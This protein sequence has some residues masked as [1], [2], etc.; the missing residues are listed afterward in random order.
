MGMRLVVLHQ[1]IRPSPSLPTLPNDS[2][3]EV[4]GDR[5]TAR[6]R[7]IHCRLW[8]VKSGGD[9]QGESEAH[10][11]IAP[12]AD[13]NS[14]LSRSVPELVS[15]I[16]LG[17]GRRTLLASFCVKPDQCCFGRAATIRGWRWRTRSPANQKRLPWC[18]PIPGAAW[19][20]KAGRWDLESP[21]NPNDPQCAKAIV[22]FSRIG[23]A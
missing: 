13:V 7:T 4:A 3:Y 14:S 16:P 8:V 15:K 19:R 5:C 12:K 11:G 1:F 18:E 17:T 20:G 9:D 10:V 6:F 21:A 23:L 22:P 2:T